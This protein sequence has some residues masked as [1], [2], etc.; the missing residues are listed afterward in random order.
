MSNWN[1]T[2][3]QSERPR[4]GAHFYE[5]P[6]I[7]SDGFRERVYGPRDICLRV[8][9]GRLQTGPVCYSEMELDGELDRTRAA[10]WIQRASKE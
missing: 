8:A 6:T 10:I 7:A 2:R 1:P 5:Y 3:A 9:L 4:Y